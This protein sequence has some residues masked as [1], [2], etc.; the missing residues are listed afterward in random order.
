MDGDE[1]ESRDISPDAM[2]PTVVPPAGRRR[3]LIFDAEFQVVPSA[4]RLWRLCRDYWW[5]LGPYLGYCA[6]LWA[7]AALIG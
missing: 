2:P 3:P 5:A 7:L 1:A 6:A 4:P